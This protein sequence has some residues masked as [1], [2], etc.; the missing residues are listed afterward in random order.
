MTTRDQFICE[1]LTPVRGSFDTAGMARG[2][3]GLPLRFTWR[4]R[5]HAV[6]NVLKVWKT[7]SREKG[8]TEI[9]L[10]RHW[11]TLTTDTGLTLTLYCDRQAKVRRRPKA[12]W[13]VYT[14][15]ADERAGRT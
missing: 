1:P 4:G 2:E 8:G 5:E 9:Y 13:W 14:V 6:V 7:S 10:R 15:A 11:W 3:P 12:R